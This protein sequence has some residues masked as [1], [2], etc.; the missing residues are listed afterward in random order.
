[1]FFYLWERRFLP[2]P[3]GRGIRAARSVKKNKVVRTH[4]REIAEVWRKEKK[5]RKGNG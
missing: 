3:K 5:T 1:L 2:M 4:A